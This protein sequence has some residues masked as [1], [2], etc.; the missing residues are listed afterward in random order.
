MTANIA[1]SFLT[2]LQAWLPSAVSLLTVN[3]LSAVFVARAAVVK[4]R[5]WISF[6]W[7]SLIATSLVMSI[8]VAALPTSEEHL[9]GRRKC[10]KC[11]EFVRSEATVCRFCHSDLEPVIVKKSKVAQTNP[12][13]LLSMFTIGLGVVVLALAATHVFT[14]SLWLGIALVLAGGVL[15]FRTPRFK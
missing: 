13:W 12:V 2:D 7:L 14:E 5:S 6:F 1:T 4:N 15:L 9:P 11:A 10:P 8:V 3:T